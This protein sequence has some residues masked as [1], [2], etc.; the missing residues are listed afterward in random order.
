VYPKPRK[1]G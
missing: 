1:P